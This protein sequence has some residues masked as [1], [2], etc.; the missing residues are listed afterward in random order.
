MDLDKHASESREVTW[1]RLHW[2]GGSLYLCSRRN[3][4]STLS[5]GHFP[6]AEEKKL[7]NGFYLLAPNLMA[8]IF[9]FFL[10]GCYSHCCRLRDT[11]IRLQFRIQNPSAPHCP[12]QPDFVS[13]W[14]H[15]P[16]NLLN[17]S[18]K[19]YS[20]LFASVKA[21][22]FYLF[23]HASEI[24]YVFLKKKN[25]FLIMLLSYGSMRMTGWKPPH[26]WSSHA[27]LD[28]KVGHTKRYVSNRVRNDLSQD[29]VAVLNHRWFLLFS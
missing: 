29:L 15:D 26:F 2:A 25:V 5:F 20:L 19:D 22:E 24:N 23:Q 17:Y 8:F 12:W 1:K 4:T 7:T 14:F 10:A 6:V 28:F 21:H 3:P 11:W 18:Y 16:H 13:E 9:F 27:F